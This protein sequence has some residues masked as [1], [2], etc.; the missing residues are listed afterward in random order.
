M[1]CISDVAF[2]SCLGI[3]SVQG[4]VG[5]LVV[6]VVTQILGTICTDGCFYFLISRDYIFSQA[7]A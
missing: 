5:E 3:F 1:L 7:L 4:S 6:T 2:G